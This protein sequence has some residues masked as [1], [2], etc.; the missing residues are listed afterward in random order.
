LAKKLISRDLK[1]LLTNLGLIENKAVFFLDK[2][3][4]ST[5]NFSSKEIEKKL[6]I[7]KPTAFY[8]FNNQPY[9]LFFDL[10][11][12]T[13]NEREEQIHK[14]VWSFDQSPLVF[15]IKYNVV[16]IFNAFTYDKNTNR[17]QKINVKQEEN[18]N[19]IFSFWNLQSGTTWD[20]LEKNYYK[21]SIQKKR[22]NQKLFENIKLVRETLT[23]SKN[24]GY[25]K[26]D[27]VNILILRLIFI[28]YLIDRNVKLDAK[29]IEGKTIL[30]RKKSFSNLISKPEEL[31]NFFERLNERFNGV[32]FKNIKV[33]LSKYQAQSLALVFNGEEPEPGTLFEGTDFYFEIFDFSIIPVEVI[34]GIYESLIDEETKKLHSAVYT[35][36]FLVEYILSNTIDTYFKEQK[37]R[38]KTDCKIFDPSVGSGIFLVQSF[39]RMVDREISLSKE[40]KISKVRLREIAQNN[41]FGVDLNEQALKVACF[42]IYIAILDYRDPNTILDNFHFP[43]LID[44]NLFGANFFDTTHSYNEIIK[45]KSLNFILG[46]PPWKSNKEDTHTNWLKA[47]NKVTGRYEIAQSFLLRSKDFMQPDTLTALIVTSTIFYNVSST[48]KKFKQEFLRQFCLDS[49]FDLSPVRRLIFEE[50]N[51]PCSIVFYRLS[52]GENYLNNIIKHQSVKSNI[53]LKYYKTIVIEKFDQ[54]KIK[55]KHFIENDWMFKVALYGNTL[56]FILL[57]KLEQNKTKISDLIDDKT[58]FKG[59]GIERG[60][61]GKYFRYLEGM[62]IIENGEVMPY[63]SFINT[64]KRLSKKETFLSRGRRVEIFEG[65]KILFKEQ[66]QDESNPLFSFIEQ[67]SV[68]RKGISSIATKD[69]ITTLKSIYSYLLSNLYT[70]FLFIRSCSW[71]V[72]T[73]PQTRLDEEYLSF[74]YIQPTNKV[75]HKLIDLVNHFLVPFQEHYKTFHLG[76]P[77]KDEFIFSKINSIIEELYQ[78]KGYE[79]DLIDYVL[80]VSRYQFQESKQYKIVHKIHGNKD[81]LKKYAD[82]FLKEFKEIYKGEYLQVLVYPLD[83]FIAMHFLFSE[84][85]PQ[86]EIRIVSDDEISNEKNIL[87]VIVKSTSISKITKDLYV[88]KDIKGF[89]ENSFYIIKPNEFKCWHRAMAWYDV[90]EIKETIEQAEIDYLKNITNAS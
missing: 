33:Q 38:H 56:D 57:K 19:E 14:Q 70:Y 35:P 22:V 15:I 12:N 53:F 76:K 24:E 89:E 87:N 1:D 11:D 61:E 20:W 21:N 4:G 90:A 84:E 45:S 26:E 40:Q 66:N 34:S 52:I 42:S 6:N 43:K 79:K 18:K 49:F 60:K 13:S 36:S 5:F 83:H 59:A 28:R 2:E 44:E 82:V 74:P 50:K 73:R 58:L 85:K 88:Q 75:K 25:L 72:S 62:P 32:L 16:E 80:E 86:E 63:Y 48:T 7:I 17:L 9:I 51:S 8:L 55:Q 27:E 39:R 68:F 29:F 31:N 37:N 64:E 65:S 46:N 3:D 10:A 69:D 77:Q 81:I 67:T 71:G 54:K 30:Q 78:I 41:L 23:N 47:N